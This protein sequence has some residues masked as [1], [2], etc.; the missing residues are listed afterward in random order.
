MIKAFLII[1]FTLPLLFAGLW[2]V[3]VPE[4]FLVERIEGALSDGSLSLRP[5]GIRKGLFWG[6]T[7]EKV[8]VSRAGGSEN[9]DD[10]SGAYPFLVLNEV[11]GRLD[12]ASFL[13]LSP[14]IALK[15]HVGKGLLVGNAG[16]LGNNT[17]ALRFEGIPISAITAL[18]RFSIQGEGEIS[19]EIT[20]HGNKGEA[21]LSVPAAKLKGAVVGGN[22]IPLEYFSSIQAA[23]DFDRGLI[24]IK[25]LRLEGRG[26]SARVT[27]NA[28]GTQ[29]DMALDIMVDSSF[30]A[31]TV[32]EPLMERYKVSP[33]Y[34]AVP[35]TFRQ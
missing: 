9:G 20:L 4:A 8:T 7:A 25:S 16:I 19:G 17:V 10:S 34:F 13:G 2:L 3:A 24:S 27:G 15:G 33:G 28:S 18:D 21:R 11:E 14:C 5:E 30:P 31:L 29:A 32:F 23:V 6:I 12:I 1:V 26:V 22:H 35:L